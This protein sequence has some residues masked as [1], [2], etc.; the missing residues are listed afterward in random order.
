MEK[1]NIN[2]FY[3]LGVPEDCT[4]EETVCV[5]NRVRNGKKKKLEFHA[6]F[7]KKTNKM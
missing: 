7:N 2:Y 3:R 1:K 4:P 6:F 5:Y